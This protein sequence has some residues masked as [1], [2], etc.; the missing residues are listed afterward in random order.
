MKQARY[1]GNRA[2]D[3]ADVPRQPPPPGSVS[4]EVA[5]I[6]VCGTDLHVYHGHMDSR[7]RPPAVIGHEMSG[8]IAEIGEGVEGW[9]IGD[10]VTV[11]PLDWCGECPACRA[12]NWHV[13]QKLTFI[14]LDAAGA[15]QQ[16]WIV[17]ARSLVRLPA[18]LSLRAAALVEPTAVAVHDVRR[19]AVAS[20]DQVAV[21]GAGPVGTLIALVAR[22][23]GADVRVFEPDAFRRKV[24]EQLGFTAIDPSAGDVVAAVDDW[25][26]GAGVP[27]AFEVSGSSSGLG[28]AVQMLAVRGRL[29]LVAIHTDKASMDLHRFFWRELSL[30]GARL[31][32]YADFEQAVELVARKVVPAEQLISRIVGLDEAAEAFETLE[33]GGSVMK[34][35][36]ECAR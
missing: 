6:G 29:C 17:P 21:I 3:I 27:V 11:M 9:S 24:A 19:A 20:G 18:E 15:M 13:C 5:Y 7:V 26:A 8:R 36:V 32:D 4:V 28:D 1:V 34:V 10:P 2:F 14:G 22:E 23:V 12:G 33:R 16:Q 25:T 30:V 35:L 31:Y